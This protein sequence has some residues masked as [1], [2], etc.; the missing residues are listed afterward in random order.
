[1]HERELI[2][3]DNKSADQK[4]RFRAVKVKGSWEFYREPSLKSRKIC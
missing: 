2:C 4:N 1:M 3:Y